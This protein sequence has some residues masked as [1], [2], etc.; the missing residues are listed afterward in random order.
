MKMEPLSVSGRSEELMNSD[1]SAMW[2]E[3]ISRTNK[4]GISSWSS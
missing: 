4:M 1:L 2:E 3:K